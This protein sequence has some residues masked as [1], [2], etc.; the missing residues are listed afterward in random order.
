[1]HGVTL[2]SSS[3]PQN[4]QGYR[5]IL[6][7]IKKRCT[8]R[9]TRSRIALY[10]S[11]HVLLLS[12]P[13]TGQRIFLSPSQFNPIPIPSSKF[14]PTHLGP[15]CLHPCPLLPTLHNFTSFHHRGRNS[16]TSTLETPFPY[17]QARS[18]VTLSFGCIT[19]QVNNR[20]LIFSGTW[21]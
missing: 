18:Q 12:A 4:S 9:R 21:K 11:A 8:Y 15:P 10:T 20:P 1:M 6:R 14:L 7:S 2:D 5:G 17:P 19:P 3:P 16:T 13:H